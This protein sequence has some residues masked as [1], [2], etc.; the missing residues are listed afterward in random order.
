M[1]KQGNNKKTEAGNNFGRIASNVG[2]SITSRTGLSIIAGAGLAA[3]AVY[4]VRK[5]RANGTLAEGM[6]ALEDGISS[7]TDEPSTGKAGRSSMRRG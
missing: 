2:R 3:A 1:N 4:A 7:L 6:E 5:L